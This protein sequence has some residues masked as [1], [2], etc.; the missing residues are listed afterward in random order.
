MQPTLAYETLERVP[1]ARPI[2]RLDYIA[3]ACAG[4][5]VLDIGCLDETALAKRDTIHW[6]HGRIAQSAQRVIGVD[7][8]AILP[9]EGIE[10]GPNARIHKGDGSNPDA[11][12]I[13]GAGV[14]M[15]VAGEFIEHIENPLG[16]LRGL[17]ARFD[18]C[19][20]IF[21]TP[22]G[23]SLANGLLG[24]IGREAQHHDHLMTSTYKT[25]NT[26]CKRAGLA[27]WTIQPYR[28]F[29]TELAMAS[30]GAMRG[31]VLAAEAGIRAA[32]LLFPLRS[33]GYIVHAK[34]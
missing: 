11:A 21:T 7:N 32:E 31:A 25:L 18:G 13:A 10:T 23:A 34:I 24:M 20:L 2:D 17:R 19:E 1:V 4:R 15:I 22:N 14:D 3:A 30:T 33:F 9:P 26:L 6:L 28:F 5:T 16:F 29:A 12:L 27:E 8:S